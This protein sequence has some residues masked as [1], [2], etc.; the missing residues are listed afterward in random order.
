MN[1]HQNA[2]IERVVQIVDFIVDAIDGERILNQIVGADGEKI[3]MG[4]EQ[5][6]AQ[7]CGRN[8]D[9]AAYRHEGIE[10]LIGS[11]QFGSR[12]NDQLQHLE[13]LLGIGQ[14]GDHHPYGPIGGSS[15]DCPQLGID[16]G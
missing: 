6:C 8:L 15:Q 4:G 13:H 16:S 7:G 9:H 3:Q 2:G 14:H 10:A 12:L 11:G 1:Q 5:V